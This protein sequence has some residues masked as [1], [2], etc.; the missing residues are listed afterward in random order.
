MSE[1]ASGQSFG[2]AL[3]DQVERIAELFDA[4]LE[5]IN[6]V[7]ELYSARVALEREY[8][9]KL[10]VLTKKAFDKKARAQSAFVVG[11]EPTKAWD[12]N[13]L[14]QSS[15]NAAYDE[16][17]TSF[18]NTAQDHLNNADALATQTIEVLRGLERKNADSKKKEM[19]FF[20]K[21]LSD[22]DRVY[23]E[24]LKSK[25]KY[26]EDC[27]EVETF[28]QKQG[29]ATDDRHADRAARQA[30]Q[31]RNDML[32][33]KNSYLIS[34]AVA[35]QAK[36]KLYEEDLPK[37]ENVIQAMQRRLV[38][39]FV[40]VL[41][42][43]QKLHL[44]HLDSL[45]SR[46]ANVEEKLKQVDVVRDQDLF[47]DHNVRPF[48][49]PDDWKFEPCSIHYDTDS[50]SID[51]APKIVIQN[52]L[53]RSREKLEELIPLMESRRTESHQL[54]SQLS[55]YIPDHTLGTID[56]LHDSYLDAEHQVVFYATSERILKTEIDV[57]VDAVGDDQGASKP[58]SFKSS[59]FSI[60]TQCGYCMVP[61]NCEESEERPSGMLFRKSTNASRS[62]PADRGAGMA[63]SASSFV[64]SIASEDS[65]V[66]ERVE[67]KV[68]FDFNATSEFEL[69]V[70]DGAY[71]HV[72][73]PDDGSGWV[74]VVDKDGNSGLVPASYLEILNGE[75]G[76]MRVVQD[77]TGDRV[78]AIYPYSAQSADELDLTVGD[79]LELSSGATGGRNYA[80]GWWEGTNVQG[81]KGIFPSNY[82]SGEI[83]ARAR[84]PSW[85]EVD[86]LSQV[87]AI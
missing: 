1:P 37:L 33:S 85:V 70:Q 75:G 79:T 34:I 76:E 77:A 18:T 13:V 21:L 35:N 80:D 12:A 74:K 49:A 43:S 71:V 16:I 55:S 58:H 28:R 27:T 86:S 41:L 46:V 22:R 61:A 81:R 31:Q 83:R 25:Q 72:L 32:N 17:L 51:P 5:V 69:G 67:A 63:P 56:E 3:P 14:R 38:E 26:D 10:Q 50:M 7:R 52:K 57:I 53:R 23:S 64:Q 19:A 45:K 9:G 44:S 73:E 87:E 68:L 66:E 84:A 29:R 78:Q 15:L 11:N 6:D 24:R 4:H 30:E 39:R 36:A 62:G 59:S 8:A 54:S 60:P 2:Q 65:S 20:Q 82:V 47:I 42:Q 48:I 40:Q